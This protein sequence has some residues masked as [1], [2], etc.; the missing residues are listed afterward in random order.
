[1]VFVEVGLSRFRFFLK[2][3]LHQ[4]SSGLF[5]EVDYLIDLTDISIVSKAILQTILHK[6]DTEC[7]YDILS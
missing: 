4:F 1:M 2:K 6:I 3:K 7:D 5:L